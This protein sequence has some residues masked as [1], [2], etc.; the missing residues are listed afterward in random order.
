LFKGAGCRMM[1]M[2]PLFGI[3]QMIYYIGVAEFL[4]GREKVKHI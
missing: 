1:V 2:A 3:A 4:L